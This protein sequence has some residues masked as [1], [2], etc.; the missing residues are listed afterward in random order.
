YVK[1]QK[2]VI[3]LSRKVVSTLVYPAILILLSVGLITIL[4]TY[5]IPRFTEFF[6]DFNA[7]LPLLTVI[8]LGTAT[9][10]KN[11]ILIIV[12]ALGI[13]GFLL[14]RWAKATARGGGVGR[15]R[16]NRAARGGSV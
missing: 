3:G 9:F 8:V 14:S 7:D 15:G 11:N 10:L 1:Y 5:V 12:G 4:M 6:A 2:T 16:P 13:G